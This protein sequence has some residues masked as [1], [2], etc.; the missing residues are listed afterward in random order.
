VAEVSVREYAVA[1]LAANSSYVQMGYEFC[2]E[3]QNSVFRGEIS[4][5]DW[6]NLVKAAKGKTPDISAQMRAINELKENL[7][8]ENCRVNF[9]E[10]SSIQDGKLIKIRVEYIDVDTNQKKADVVLIV[11]QKPENGDVKLTDGGLIHHLET[12][13]LQRMQPGGAVSTGT[14]VIHDVLIFHTPVT[15]TPANAPVAAPD[16]KPPPPAIAA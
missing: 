2:N 6:Y 10:H 15:K 16:R 4:P 11:N 13:G 14:P 9:K 8:V 7:H 1:A 5:Q 3:K 12:S